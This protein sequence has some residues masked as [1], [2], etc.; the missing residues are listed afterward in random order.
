LRRVEWRKEAV[1]GESAIEFRFGHAMAFVAV[2]GDCYDHAMKRWH[3]WLELARI[4]NLP[5]VW[6][7][8][9][10]GWLLAGGAWH[11]GPL[12]WL[13]LGGSLLYTAGMI[14][15]DAMDVKFDREHRKERPIPSGRVSPAT[16]WVV[17]VGMLVVG[18]AMSYFGGGACGWLVL[19]L[20]GAIVAYDAF[21]KPWAGSVLIMGACRALLYLVAASAASDYLTRLEKVMV[22]GRAS[23]L[24]G[25]IIGVTLVARNESKAGGHNALLRTLGAVALG[26]PIIATFVL[27]HL[28]PQ[29]VISVWPYLWILPLAL[30]IVRAYVLMHSPPA[31]NIG[32]AVGLLLAGIVIVDAMAVSYFHPV[33]AVL[34]AGSAPF[35]LLWQ[36][37]I[38]AT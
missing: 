30:V 4:S 24:G 32:R 10:A 21:H 37:K 34:F 25:Y 1:F 23:A 11:W 26:L 13:L 5:T 15:N 28:A 38:A 18:A 17:G 36:R 12:A 14:L 31:A 7:N 3:A 33:A 19:A 6:T 16:A 9:L 2:H 35:L 22:L 20:V 29:C 27:P 8:V